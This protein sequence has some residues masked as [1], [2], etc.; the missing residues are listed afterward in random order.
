M[1]GSAPVDL[2]RRLRRLRVAADRHHA[3]QAI[4]AGGGHLENTCAFVGLD[5]E[6]VAEGDDFAGIGG[7][8][9]ARNNDADKIHGIS[10]GDGN[11]FAGR[12]QMARGAQRFH[13]DG[14]SEL[15]TQKSADETA[16]AN[17]AAIFQPAQSDQQLA[18]LGKY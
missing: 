11:D 9:I 17:F 16:A 14:Q 3:G 4:S 7:D 12:L 6:A 8:A 1:R 10:G 5:G 13:S 18:P 15:L 2:S